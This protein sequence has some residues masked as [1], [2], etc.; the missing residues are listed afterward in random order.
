MTARVFFQRRSV[1]AL[2]VGGLALYPTSVI[3]EAPSHQR[4]PIY[5]D[6]DT[7][8]RSIAPPLSSPKQAPSAQQAAPAAANDSKTDADAVLIAQPYR[9]PTPTD[10]L[11]VQIGS[12][13]LFLHDCAAATEDR[14]NGAMDA[15][16]NLEHSFTTTIASLAPPRES[17]EK[18]MPGV[19]YL[20][21]AAMAGSVVTRNRGFLLRTTV[22]L[23]FGVGAGWLLLPITMRNVAN[24]T[25]SYEKRFPAIADA[26]LRLREGFDQSL[27]FAKSHSQAGKRYVDE[28]VTDAREAVE[29]WVKQGK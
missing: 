20:L 4:K 9:G 26:H 3:A 23:A 29:G 1:A 6:F 16:F 5:D 2:A 10:R 7:S 25:W 19:I 15:A 14:V 8:A 28:K 27:N 22:P 11:A 13:R 17:G 18:L 21:V 24:M 12:V